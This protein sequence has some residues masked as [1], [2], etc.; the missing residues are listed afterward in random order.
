MFRRETILDWSYG[1]SEMAAAGLSLVDV[2]AG[3]STTAVVPYS[4]DAD[5]LPIVATLPHLPNKYCTPEFRQPLDY[6]T[7]AFDDFFMR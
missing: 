7:V 2:P 1:P 6:C 3:F 5:S 4:P